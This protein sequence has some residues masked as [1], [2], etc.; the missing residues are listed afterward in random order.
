M[1]SNGHSRCRPPAAGDEH[2]RAVNMNIKLTFKAIHMTDSVLSRSNSAARRD[3]SLEVQETA[4]KHYD[5]HTHGKA[6]TLPL[7]HGRQDLPVS[8]KV[9]TPTSDFARL[10]I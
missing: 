6:P 1:I 9:P 2:S 10:E 4:R 8:Q 3:L 7:S 5:M